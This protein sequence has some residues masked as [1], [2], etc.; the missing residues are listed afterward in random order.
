[1]NLKTSARKSGLQPI[2]SSWLRGFRPIYEKELV[3]WFAKK[4]WISQLVLW[5][6]LSGVPTISLITMGGTALSANQGIGILSLFLWLGTT[7][8][9]IGTIVLSQGAIIEEKLTSTLLWIC[10]KPLSRPAFI[11]GKFAA[12]AVF[13]ASI[14]LGTPAL[15]VYVTAGIFGLP[16][17]VSLL[18]YLISVLMIYLL[19]LFLLAVTL[20]L[21]TFFNNI[22]IVT[23]LALLVFIGGASLNTNQQL[24]QIEPVSFAALQRYAVEAV[25]GHI[26]CQALIAM[27]VTFLLTVGCLALASWQM[28][29]HEL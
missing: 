29:R 1:M 28:E 14:M 6:G 23:A 10:S 20:M 7:P 15:I 4:R 18:S 21:G 3:R 2:E 17:L 27:G 12:Y 19:L 24:R 5:I 13:I 22:G 25:A 9:S 8:M 16:S 11:L 26:P